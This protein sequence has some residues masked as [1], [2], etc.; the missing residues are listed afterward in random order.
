MTDCALY[1]QLCVNFIFIFFWKV[2]QIKHYISNTAPAPSLSHT[3]LLSTDFLAKMV[4]RSLLAAHL[5]KLQ[6]CP[7]SCSKQ[8][9]RLI[10]PWSQSRSA[11]SARRAIHFSIWSPSWDK[12]TDVDWFSFLCNCEPCLYLTGRALYLSGCLRQTHIVISVSPIRQTIGRRLRMQLLWYVLIFLPLVQAT[13]HVALW[14]TSSCRLKTELQGFFH[15]QTY[16]HVFLNTINY[17]TSDL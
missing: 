12:L 17:K 8:V 13:G 11:P 3:C 10:A 6:R 14:K 2:N 5:A 9:L 1:I 15:N 7:L 16:T 4:I